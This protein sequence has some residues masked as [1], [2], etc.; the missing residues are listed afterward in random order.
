MRHLPLTS[1]LMSV[2]EVSLSVNKYRYICE[3]YLS[4][5]LKVSDHPR[6]WEKWI[7]F[8]SIVLTAGRKEY[9][10]KIS[11][12]SNVSSWIENLQLDCKVLSVTTRVL[13]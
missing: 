8:H 9:N 10:S 2:K 4:I 6:E 7:P 5:I 11:F 1:K 3:H 12:L 13:K